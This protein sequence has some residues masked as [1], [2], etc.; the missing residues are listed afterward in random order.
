MR[1]I[2]CRSACGSYRQP[3]VPNMH[4]RLFTVAAGV[5]LALGLCTGVMGCTRRSAQEPQASAPTVSVSY[6]LQRQVTDYAEFT[7]QTAPIDSV[8][9]RARV[10][11]YLDK[12]NF[13]EG[14]EVKQG[15]V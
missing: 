7:G 15:D 1:S 2:S 10:S 5:A 6:P 8:Q 4:S 9:V 14:A 3:D 12:I 13:K 11:G